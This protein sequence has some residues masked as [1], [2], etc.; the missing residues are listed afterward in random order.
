MVRVKR[1]YLTTDD[2]IGLNQTWKVYPCLNSINPRFCPFFYAN[3]GL[4]WLGWGPEKKQRK[5]R[6]KYLSSIDDGVMGSPRGFE[7]PQLRWLNG[8][9]TLHSISS[10]GVRHILSNSAARSSTILWLHIVFV[11]GRL[12]L[13]CL[14][15]FSV[16]KRILTLFESL[17]LRNPVSPHHPAERYN[18]PPKRTL[19]PSPSPSCFD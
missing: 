11:L 4:Q 7:M 6:Q 8:A 17:I 9:F 16:I 1:L 13:F 5:I 19:D 2:N 12:D 15:I 18:H 14:F 3:V 10:L